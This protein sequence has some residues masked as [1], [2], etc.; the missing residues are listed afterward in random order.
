[1]MP[2]SSS[3]KRLKWYELTPFGAAFFAGLALAVIAIPLLDRVDRVRAAPRGGFISF[4][5]ITFGAAVLGSRL[6]RRILVPAMV[7]LWL[8]A[9]AVLVRAA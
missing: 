6:P 4:M 9:L 2:E 1:M 3:V 7:V 5:A 8:I